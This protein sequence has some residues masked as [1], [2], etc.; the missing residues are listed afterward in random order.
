MPTWSSSG[1]PSLHELYLDDCPEMEFLPQGSMPSSLQRLSIIGCSKLI[2]SCRDWDLH[3][4][5]SLKEFKTGGKLE[6]HIES[7]PKKEGL[8]LPNLQS[9]S[10]LC[11]TNLKRINHRGILNL[12]SLTSS[13]CFFACPS[14]SFEGMPEDGLPPSLSHLTIGC[15]CRLLEER[16]EKEERPDW[17]K[18][19]HIPHVHVYMDE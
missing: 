5:L 10:F 15:G 16:C 3:E 9:L 12:H 18:I 19:A 11:C 6:G 14:M 17:P 13:S 4:L 7:F 2:E 1:V 8:L